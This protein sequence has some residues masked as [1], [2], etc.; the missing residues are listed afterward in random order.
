MDD[1]TAITFAKHLPTE[2]AI[3][4]LGEIQ[5][6][7]ILRQALFG[8]PWDTWTIDANAIISNKGCNALTACHNLILSAVVASFLRRYARYDP[9][10]AY[11][12]TDDIRESGGLTPTLRRAVTYTRQRFAKVLPHVA[13]KRGLERVIRY[14]PGACE[15]SHTETDW[16]DPYGEVHKGI[17]RT[18]QVRT[19]EAY[20]GTLAKYAKAELAKAELAKAEDK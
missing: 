6:L 12:L 8:R 15:Y 19:D 14:H 9:Q 18:K 11:E 16:H 1:K 4:L 2:Q 20:D 13:L 17:Y 5:D 7:E 3:R 10:V